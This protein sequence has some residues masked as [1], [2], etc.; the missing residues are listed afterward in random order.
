MINKKINCVDTSSMGR[1]FDAVSS[2]IGICNK[3]TYEGQ[4]SIELEA[5]IP[6]H[7]GFDKN[8]CYKYNLNNE[9]DVIEINPLPIIE[10]I[11]SDK[12]SNVSKDTISLKFHNTVI[13]F[14]IAVCE[15]LRKKTNIDKVALSGGVFQNYY[16]IKNLSIQLNKINFHVYTQCQF[17]S[18][19]GGVALGQIVI[20]DNL[21]KE[22]ML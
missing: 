21:L 2:I 4:G 13:N 17:P 6:R 18:N 1:L 20:G 19:D 3:A 11:L 7:T 9:I 5:L 22:R 14:T 16:L 10:G 8:L 12:V 15:K